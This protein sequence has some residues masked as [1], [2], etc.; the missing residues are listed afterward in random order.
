[1]KRGKSPPLI[2]KILKGVLPRGQAPSLS[3]AMRGIEQDDFFGFGQGGFLVGGI[4]LT[5]SGSTFFVQ[6]GYPKEEIGR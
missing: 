1:M 2:A 6:G 3:R 5:T 4:P